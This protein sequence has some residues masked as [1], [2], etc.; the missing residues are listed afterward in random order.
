MTASAE[1]RAEELARTSYGRL[2]AILAASSRDIES[3]EDALADAFA[4]ALST[5]P[6]SG[7]PNKP[8]AWL[9]T[10]AR[11]RQ[12]DVVRSAA[13]RLTVS[14]DDVALGAIAEV[15]DSLDP[16]RALG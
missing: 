6:E 3:A 4:R 7:V 9:L 2:L 13:D 11:N 5:W 15:L 12:R 8:E 16:D 10:V 14:I 1:V